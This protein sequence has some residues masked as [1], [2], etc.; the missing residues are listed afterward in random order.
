MS[1]LE[2]KGVDSGYGKLVIVRGVEIR[3]RDRE[4]VTIIGPN[5]SGKSTVLK[6]I[7]GLANLMAGEIRFKGELINGKRPHELASIGI[8]YVPQLDNVFTSLTVEE[9]LEMGCYLKP[10]SQV[11][12]LVEEVYSLFPVL[13][14]RAKERAGNL[15]G[16][17]RQMLAIA[18]ALV[19]KPKLLLL[20]EPTASLAPKFVAKVL[21]K[22]VEVRDLGVSILLV[23]QNAK[24][25]LEIA[26]RGYVMAAGRVVYEGDAKDILGNEELSKMYL[27]KAA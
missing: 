20:D 5:G 16:G 26:D 18:R 6:T 10:K 19:L 25:A 13:K 14:E 27:G 11:R 22:I 8:G 23:E 2:L 24:K 1:I 21:E 9:N 17:E 4:V 3:V 12:E 15:S 7:M